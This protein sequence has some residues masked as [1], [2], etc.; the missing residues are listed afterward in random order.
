MPEELDPGER[1][2]QRNPHIKDVPRDLKPYFLGF[3]IKG[4]RWNDP[5]GVDPATLMPLHLA[6]IRKQIESGVYKIA[7]P[8]VDDER[9]AGFMIIAARTAAEAIAIASEDPAIKAGRLTVE[10]HT[11]FLPSLDSLR[12]E[13]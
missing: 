9:I 2:P 1:T 5:E 6:H 7:G 11:A 13:Y 3:L 8:V 10:V 4:E 12:I